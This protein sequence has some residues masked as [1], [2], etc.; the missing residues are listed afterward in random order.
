MSN[1]YPNGSEWRQW[2]PHV[3]IPANSF[4]IDEISVLNESLCL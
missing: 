3:H 1:N 2:D 4:E